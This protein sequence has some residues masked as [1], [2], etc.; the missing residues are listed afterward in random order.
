MRKT[1]AILLIGILLFGVMASGC[2]GGSGTTTS[3]TTSSQVPATSSTSLQ[4]ASLTLVGPDGS[5]KTLT[6]SDL[7]S[8]PQTVG[9]GG[10]KTKTGKIKHVGT[11]KG[12]SL[13]DL[14]SK[15]GWLS[16][17]YRYVITAADGY[18]ITADYDFILGK[19]MDIFDEKGNPTSG[20]IIPILAYEYNGEPIKFILDGK[21]YPFK[22]AFVGNRTLIT[23]GNRWVKAVVKIEVVKAETS[24]GSESTGYVEVGD[25]A[26]RTVKVKSPPTKIVSLYG[27]ATQ[28]IYFLGVEDGKKVVGGTPLAINDAFIQILDPNVKSRMVFVGSPKDANVETVKSL[29]PDVV[30]T[31][32]WGSEKINE[33][34]ESLG[35]PVIA[36]NLETVNGY[37]NGLL[38]IGKILG[39]KE[40]AE[41]A[42]SYYR[43]V[44]DFITNRTSKLKESEK[45]R[46]LLIEYSMKDKAFKA[47]GREFFQNRLIEMAGGE[48]VSKD[49]PGGWN[50]VNVEQ[51]AKWNPDVIIVVS[52]SLKNPPTKVKAE[53]LNDPAWQTIK[54]V[55]EG[56][57]YAM[58]N[59][60]E[61]WDYPAPKWILGLYWLAKVLHPELFSDVDVKAKANEFYREFYGVAIADKVK[62]IGDFPK[63][64]STITVTDLAGRTVKIKRPIRRIVTPYPLALDLI[65]MFG[66]GDK[67]VGGFKRALNGL[68]LSID[69]NASKRMVDIGTPWSPNIEE[70]IELSPQIVFRAYHGQIDRSTEQ[71]EKAG[72]PVVCVNMETVDNFFRTIMLMGKVFGKE[73]YAN[74]ILNYYNES[75][76]IIEQRLTNVEKPKVL[77]VTYRSKASAFR[78]P[79]KGM[80]QNELIEMAGGE[81]VTKDLS[82]G[83]VDVNVEQIAKWNPDVVIV[84]SY[85]SSVPSS[86]VKE[87][88]LKDPAW[89]GIKAVKENKVY[90]MP[91][92]SGVSWDYPSSSWILGLWWMSKV[93]HP[94]KFEDVDIVKVAD[95]FYQRFYGVSIGDL[96]ITG[97]I[98]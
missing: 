50:V 77:L 58:P 78:V 20:S 3:P 52:Y 7:K 68:I 13:K 8:L 81:S 60:G 75:M 24:E 21:I 19:G 48:S 32:Y 41:R 92:V 1:G 45:P 28:M 34:I 87:M 74:Y 94:Q 27:L 47:P 46:V 72:I 95:K 38:T 86:K 43:S 40:R 79:G 26:N 80:F 84:V 15:F 93:L 69:P 85:S 4:V 31:A 57:V 10:L 71:L 49:L 51:V 22:L 25:F 6:P 18:S 29:N 36:L 35:I 12:V 42:I 83:W 97:D 61:S 62:I 76:E 66:E 89:Q 5:V 59:D 54:A 73:E 17:S 56:K 9:K 63:T 65:Y 30:F 88:I 70:I 98:P 91:S 11:Y 64:E 53:I 90:A 55:K 44:V 96:N 82:S 67:V 14:L 33:A 23:P 37:L 16:K 39:K 2:I